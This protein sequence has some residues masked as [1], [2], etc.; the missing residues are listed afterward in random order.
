M[1]LNNSTTSK[2]VSKIDI[3]IEYHVSKSHAQTESPESL[4]WWR[5]EQLNTMDLAVYSLFNPIL[6]TESNQLEAGQLWL[7]IVDC[8]YFS[9]YNCQIVLFIPNVGLQVFKHQFLTK[10]FKLWTYNVAKQTWLTP[11]QSGTTLTTS[12]PS[13]TLPIKLFTA[14]VM[15]V[16]KPS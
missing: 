2:N 11:N 9:V 8:R 16:L 12:T 7:T 4:L 14:Q 1:T 6:W 3:F 13:S 5:R 15:F 10:V